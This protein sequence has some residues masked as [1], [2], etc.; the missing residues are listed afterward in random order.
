MYKI[1]TNPILVHM[2]VFLESVANPGLIPNTLDPFPFCSCISFIPS[3]I[4][5]FFPSNTHVPVYWRPQW[6]SRIGLIMCGWDN[7]WA[8][9]PSESG[10]V[11]RA[12][13]IGH[14]R[15]STHLVR[16]DYK[17]TRSHL[18]ELS[19]FSTCSLHHSALSLSRHDG[20]RCCFSPSVGFVRSKR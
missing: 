1:N 5:T 19:C 11:L 14:A 6:L 16:A 13:E 9:P 12:T 8:V 17:R 20:Q 15:E 18:L 3:S 4:L 2:F 7:W 10:G